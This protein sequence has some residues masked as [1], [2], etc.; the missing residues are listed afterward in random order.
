MDFAIAK[1]LQEVE[2]VV[3]VQELYIITLLK[4]VQYELSN[5]PA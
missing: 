4:A 2:Q 3:L 5:G 1:I